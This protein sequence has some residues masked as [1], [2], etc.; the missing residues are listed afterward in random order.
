M[1]KTLLKSSLIIGVLAG[2]FYSLLFIT[3]FFLDTPLSSGMY[4]ADLGLMAFF[5][6]I[7]LIYYRDYNNYQEMGF[8][9]GLMAGGI[10]TLVSALVVG[11]FMFVLLQLILPHA[12]SDDAQKSIDLLL[13]T[14]T[15]YIEQYGASGFEEQLNAFKTVTVGQILVKKF[16]L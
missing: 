4:H 2:F 11:A 3:L 15:Y 13:K 16:I 10:F 12:L 9:E 5:V 1:S 8:L 6:F 14:K 7:A